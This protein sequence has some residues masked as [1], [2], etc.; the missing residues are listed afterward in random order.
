[1]KHGWMRM[2]MVA[3]GKTALEIAHLIESV[4][5]VEVKRIVI[6]DDVAEVYYE[7][8]PMGYEAV[9]PNIDDS[10]HDEGYWFAYDEYS[11]YD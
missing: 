5:N 10:I 6:R 4:S 8:I 7:P 2:F 11:D 9:V 3:N 1:M